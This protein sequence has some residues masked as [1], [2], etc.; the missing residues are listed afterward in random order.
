MHTGYVWVSDKFSSRFLKGCVSFIGCLFR[1]K[2]K[3]EGEQQLHFDVKLTRPFCPQKSKPCPRAPCCGWTRTRKPFSLLLE[4]RGLSAEQCSLP[5]EKN[6][7]KKYG[8][9]RHGTGT[10][11]KKDKWWSKIKKKKRRVVSNKYN[12]VKNERHTKWSKNEK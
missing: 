9:D 2:G 11:T 7:R 10:N 12:K 3:W 6:D 8:K 4:Q 1:N 5:V